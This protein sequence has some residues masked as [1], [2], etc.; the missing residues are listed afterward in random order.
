MSNNSRKKLY[1]LVTLPFLALLVYG[2]RGLINVTFLDR[3]ISD[4][5]R[6]TGSEPHEIQGRCKVESRGLI[7]SDVSCLLTRVKE[8][9]PTHNILLEYS[10]VLNSIMDFSDSIETVD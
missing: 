3:G 8:G 6:L 10:L 5:A 2:N 7:Q 9:K 1:A 4:A